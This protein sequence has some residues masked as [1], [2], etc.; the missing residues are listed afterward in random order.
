MAGGGFQSSIFSNQLAVGG[1]ALIVTIASAPTRAI[2]RKDALPTK[3]SLDG[4]KTMRTEEMKPEAAEAKIGCHRSSTV[5]AHLQLNTVL[6]SRSA[7][8]QP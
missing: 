6:A 5:S 2:A 7:A 1:G 4:I 3:P 8:S